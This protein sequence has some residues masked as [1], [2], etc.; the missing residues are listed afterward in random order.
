M[1][2]KIYKAE[3]YVLGDSLSG[4]KFKNKFSEVDKLFKTVFANLEIL[5]IKGTDT[6]AS[7]IERLKKNYTMQ[8]EHDIH[9]SYV[10]GNTDNQTMVC[11]DNSEEGDNIE[12]F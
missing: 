11:I 10:N 7:D 2:M 4:E 12:W 6:N 1:A 8:S 5:G 3:V 9:N